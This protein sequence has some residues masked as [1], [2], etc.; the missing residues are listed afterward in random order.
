[1]RT[2]LP[3]AY[4]RC[5]AG[6][7]IASLVPTWD[8][9]AAPAPA[10]IQIHGGKPECQ[11][12]GRVAL[13]RRPLFSLDH[14]QQQRAFAQEGTPTTA[15]TWAVC[16]PEAGMD[17]RP[18]PVRV[19]PPF[20]ADVLMDCRD[21]LLATVARPSS[22]RRP[23]LRSGLTAGAADLAGSIP[24]RSTNHEAQPHP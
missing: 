8:G 6:Y 24:V 13:T 14:A 20:R 15:G 7:D 10:A 5:A 18:V 16:D 1:M 2:L 11:T 21:V 12:P 9:V 22:A 19:R 3:A 23:L 4:N 17:W